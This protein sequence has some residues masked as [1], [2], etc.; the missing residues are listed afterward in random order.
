[1]ANQ[2]KIENKLTSHAVWDRSTRVFHWV[3]AICVLALTVLG[4]AILNEKAFG[5]SS[6]G[7]ILLKTLHSYI[8]YVF[9]VNLS[10]RV[11][12]A[13][14]GNPHA[15]W[16]AILPLEPG[17]RR[18][19]REYVRGFFTGNAPSYVG[20]N[21]LGRLMV[22]LLLIVLA[23][24]AVTGLVIAGTDLYQ[25]PFGGLFADWVTNADPEKLAQLTPGSKEYVDLAAYDEMRRFRSPVAKTHLYSFYLL[26][27]MVLLHIVGVIVTEVRE[28]NGLISAMFTGEKILSKAP[29]DADPKPSKAKNASQNH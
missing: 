5:V 20:H 25:P 10:W 9:V 23:T 27:A 15:R 17:F 26:M 6:D 24:Q 14:L 21:P 16:R 1:M 2:V 29:V 13:F 3:N 18:A 7:K 22:S 19:L 28:K 11:I 4:L 8:G 12:W